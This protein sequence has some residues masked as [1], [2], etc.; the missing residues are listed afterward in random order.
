[1]LELNV[2]QGQSFAAPPGTTEDVDLQSKLIATALILVSLG[3]FVAWLG[4]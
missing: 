2:G 3:L 1:V 4:G